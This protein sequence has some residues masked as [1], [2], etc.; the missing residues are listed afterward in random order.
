MEERTLKAVEMTSTNVTN[1]KQVAAIRGGHKTR[2]SNRERIKDKTKQT[3]I[4]L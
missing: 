1:Y 3:K 4:P 2:E